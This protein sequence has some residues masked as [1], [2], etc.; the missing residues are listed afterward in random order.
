[1][2]QWFS[3]NRIDKRVTANKTMPGALAEKSLIQST[4][5]LLADDLAAGAFTRLTPLVRRLIANNPSPFTFAGTCS[6]IVGAGDV[7]IIDPGPEDPAHL[8]ALLEATHEETIRYIVVTHTHRDHS[9][10]AAALKKAS[11]ATIVGARP[12]QPRFPGA[13][14]QGLDAAHDLTYAPDRVLEDGE[15]VDADSFTLEAVATP[16]HSANHL[17]FALPQESSLFSGDCVMAWSTSVIAPPDG[18]MGAYMAS[19]DRLRERGESLYWPGHGGPVRDPQRYVRGLATHRRQREASILA[20]LEA[21]DETIPQIVARIYES[22]NPSLV[23][24]AS[25]STLAHL[26]DLIARGLVAGEG[27][28]VLTG[29]FR[30]I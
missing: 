8:A 5:A 23:G 27:G 19:L 26:E 9:T 25:L 14:M 20:R 16:G 22:L 21:G 24:A 7:A 15:R 11:G 13:G 6:Y 10:A 18:S 28:P 3:I 30:L 17:A 12:F 2:F 4:P 1:V 29:R